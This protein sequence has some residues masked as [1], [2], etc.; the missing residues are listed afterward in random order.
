MKEQLDAVLGGEPPA[1]PPPAAAPPAPA[2]AARAAP[3]AAAVPNKAPARGG[4]AAPAKAAAAPPPPPPPPPVPLAP[5]QGSAGKECYC[6]ATVTP[7]HAAHA[8]CAQKRVHASFPTPKMQPSLWVVMSANSRSFSHWQATDRSSMDL[9]SS[10]RIMPD[11]V[12]PQH[13]RL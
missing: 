12:L 7:F 11:G 10:P 2:R 13:T 5:G 8:R 9:G 4:K 1:A 3:A 6:T